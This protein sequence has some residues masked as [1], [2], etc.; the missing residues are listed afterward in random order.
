[1]CQWP[2]DSYRISFLKLHTIQSSIVCEK[3]V[4][5]HYISGIKF[6]QFLLGWFQWFCCCW[7]CKRW[8]RCWTCWLHAMQRCWGCSLDHWWGTCW[9][10]WQ[11]FHSLDRLP[12]LLWCWQQSDQFAQCSPHTSQSHRHDRK[13]ANHKCHRARLWLSPQFT[14]ICFLILCWQLWNSPI[15]PGSPDKWSNSTGNDYSTNISSNVVVAE[16]VVVY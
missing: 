14:D 3:T 11:R 13:T 9:C 10:G 8:L 4:D 1:M 15:F 5:R 6:L 16:V 12:A 7:W 2:L